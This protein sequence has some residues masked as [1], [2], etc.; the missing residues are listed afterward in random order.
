MKWKYIYF[1]KPYDGSDKY[2]LNTTDPNIARFIGELL[3]VL[4]IREI[5][6][7]FNIS[8]V[9]LGYLL[10]DNL[11][12]EEQFLYYLL[13]IDS[14]TRYN[15]HLKYCEKEF[16]YESEN[17]EN[18]YYAM[19]CNPEY[20]VKDVL[21]NIYETNANVFKA[22]C[23]GF[24]I[25][26]KIFYNKFFNIGKSKIRIYDIDK[27]LTM[28]KLGKK[29][30]KTYIF[31]KVQLNV[32]KTHTVYKWFEEIMISDTKQKYADMYKQFDASYIGDQ[33]K[34]D[35]HTELVSQQVFKQ[36]VL[37]YWTGSRG[38]LNQPYYIDILNNI[39]TLI[40]SQTCS[41]TLNL[42][43]SSNLSSK[44]ML[45]DKFMEMFIADL[46]SAYSDR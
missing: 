16:K 42:P 26:K 2:I 44:Q 12:A 18:Y 20:I 38:I 9:Y 39:G 27:M 1:K 5:Y 17:D 14:E 13:D 3:C 23:K 29:A 43:S 31:D 46:E 28:I 25:E 30:L 45:F 10:Y 21:T 33:N 41:S 22:F 40:K 34:Q 4:I 6:L 37:L 15:Y 7:D 8:T 24:F 19:A 32:E 36:K 35:A 11:K